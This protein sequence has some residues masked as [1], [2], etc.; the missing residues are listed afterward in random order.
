MEYNIAKDHYQSLARYV[1]GLEG[2]VADRLVRHTVG[3][4]RQ[5]K[6][7]Q[8]ADPPD[9]SDEF[10]RDFQEVGGQMTEAASDCR[11]EAVGLHEHAECQ[12]LSTPSIFSEEIAERSP[13]LLADPLFLELPKPVC[14]NESIAEAN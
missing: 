11:N 7:Q 1:I 4:R 10:H 3:P 12:Y 5:R 6:D 8:Q 14:G 13:F 2:R 9:S